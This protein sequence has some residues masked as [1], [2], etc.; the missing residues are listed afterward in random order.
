MWFCVYLYCFSDDSAVVLSNFDPAVK[1]DV[2]LTLKYSAKN[3][4]NLV[5]ESFGTSIKGYS[6]Y[7]RFLVSV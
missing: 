3:S 1:G 7:E 5:S 2:G 6:F 4:L